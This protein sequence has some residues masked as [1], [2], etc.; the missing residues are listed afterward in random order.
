MV[1]RGR[2]AGEAGGGS[3]R[4]SAG[5]RSEGVAERIAEVERARDA[6]GRGAWAEAY[7]QL[8][9]VDLSTLAPR[10]LEALADAAWWLSRSEE[11]FAVRQRAYSAYAAAGQ[12]PRAAWCAGRLCV[13]H[14]LRG[15]PA[16]GAGWLMRAQRHLRDQPEC[17][18]HGFLALFE[19]AVAQFRGEVDEAASLAERATELGQRFGDRD[20]VAMGIHLQGLA[21]ISAGGVAEGMA[22][23]DEAMTWVVAGELNPYFTGVIYCNVLSICLELADLARAAEWNKAATAWCES[24]PE[25][26]PFPGLCRLNRIEAANLRGAWSDA[27]TEAKRASEELTF[28]PRAAGHA[29]YETGE[30]RRRIGNFAGAEE[31]FTRAHELG[32]DPQPGLALLRLAQGKAEAALGALWLAVAGNSGSRLRRARLLRRRRQGGGPAGGAGSPAGRAHGTGGRGAPPGR[33]RQDQPRG[34]R[35]AHRQRAHRRAAPP[36]H[37]RQTGCLVAGGRDRLRGR[38]RPRL[39][40]PDI[41]PLHTPMVNSDHDAH[42][43]IGWFRRCPPPVDPPR[44]IPESDREERDGRQQGCGA[45]RDGDHRRRAGGPFHG[46][47]PA[48]ARAAVRD[49]GG[50]PTHR[51]L[52][53][54]ALGL[55]APVHSRPARRPAGLA[56]PSALLVVP[57]QGRDGRLPRSLRGAL[58]SPGADRHARGRRLQTGRAVRGH[59]G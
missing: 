31:A 21:R 6:I 22:L 18:E 36:E 53:A 27:E 17:V 35:G 49:P 24:L 39:S 3:G 28:N 23:L 15:E 44:V 47:P 29:F 14:F 12:H 10:D 42:Q 19:A 13:E 41:P 48:P 20:L 51:G 55:A 40:A 5:G 45:F 54:Q 57:N 16:V 32:F 8:R 2:R 37:L 50:E 7:D 58:R 34:R 59:R 26:A 11:S 46:L 1:P 33:R 9:T 38:A 43:R 52:L 4:P 30:I 25:D 56:V